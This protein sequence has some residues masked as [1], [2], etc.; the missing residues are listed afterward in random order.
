M[1]K[2]L[3]ALPPSLVD[4]V[5]FL[6]CRGKPLDSITTISA[7]P[8]TTAQSWNLFSYFWSS[9]SHPGAIEPSPAPA[10]VPTSDKESAREFGAKLQLPEI[11]RMLRSAH[12]ACV[13]AAFLSLLSAVE[14]QMA[15]FQPGVRDA[16]HDTC[17]FL[18]EILGYVAVTNLQKLGNLQ[19]YFAFLN[20]LIA[21]APRPSRL[22][23]CGVTDLMRV[24][25]QV[26]CDV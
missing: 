10:A 22:L 16:S 23:E 1:L 2:R 8:A 11:F 21:V 9:G 19:R 12:E 17:L 7:A 13:D 15:V 14:N 18:T 25:I 26:T 24:A 6:D 5:E 3:D 20:A 4:H